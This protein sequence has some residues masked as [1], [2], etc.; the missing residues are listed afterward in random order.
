MTGPSNVFEGR[1]GFF[2]VM[3]RKPVAPPQLGEPF[4]VRRASPSA[5]HLANFSKLSR[6]LPWKQGP[7]SRVRTKS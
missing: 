5:S 6:K 4:G 7:I 1:Y 3:S 2:K